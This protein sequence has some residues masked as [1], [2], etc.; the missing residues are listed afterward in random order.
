MDGDEFPR[1]D[2]A[3][4][5]AE[6]VTTGVARGVVATLDIHAD[7][8][9]DCVSAWLQPDQRQPQVLH[10]IPES[11]EVTLLLIER[12]TQQRT[13]SQHDFIEGLE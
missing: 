9:P 10:P 6:F 7:D 12:R 5:L 3:H 4:E 1:G 11:Y 13:M 2:A 8:M